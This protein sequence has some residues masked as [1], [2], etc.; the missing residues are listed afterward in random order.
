[1]Q[2]VVVVSGFALS[3]GVDELRE[4]RIGER[5]VHAFEFGVEAAP[6]PAVELRVGAVEHLVRHRH[7]HHW[8]EI[9]SVD[10]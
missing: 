10:A 7:R 4:L 9:R 6:F 5:L 8:G 3:V 2:F 1:M